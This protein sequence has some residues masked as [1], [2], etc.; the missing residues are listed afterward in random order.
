MIISKEGVKI[1]RFG[2]LY[3]FAR[4]TCFLGLEYVQACKFASFVFCLKSVSKSPA[5]SPG[6]W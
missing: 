5:D 4:R 2:R 1:G 6:I 3:F